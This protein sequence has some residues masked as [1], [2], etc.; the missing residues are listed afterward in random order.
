MMRNSYGEITGYLGVIE[1]IT[2]RIQAQRER[3][4]KIKHAG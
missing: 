3:E 2:E 1:D 4:H